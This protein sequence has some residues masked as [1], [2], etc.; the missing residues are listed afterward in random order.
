MAP[1]LLRRLS[2]AVRSPAVTVTGRCLPGLMA[3]KG[4]RGLAE[5][6]TSD[7]SPAPLLSVGLYL[8]RYGIS[9]DTLNK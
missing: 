4:A 7:F 3:R 1:R 8:M 2:W 9:S 6:R 5:V